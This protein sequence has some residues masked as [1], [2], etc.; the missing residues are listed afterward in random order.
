MVGLLILFTCWP[1]IHAILSLHFGF[2][3]W[4]FAGWGMYATP[5]TPK[6]ETL[7]V[8]IIPDSFVEDTERMR[9]HVLRPAPL[10]PAFR[11]FHWTQDGF[12]EI[13]PARE[14]HDVGRSVRLVKVLGS[15]GSVER[16]GESI[17]RDYG[18]RRSNPKMIVLVIQPRVHPFQRI[19]YAEVNAYLY[20]DHQAAKLGT[21]Q[22]DETDINRLLVALARGDAI[23]DGSQFRHDGSPGSQPPDDGPD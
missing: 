11:V 10:Q 5:Y 14:P 12:R 3:A 15:R 16:L 7:Q 6:T 9:A 20:R 18:I 19:T 4:K 1:P 13:A 8:Y 2:S 22:S 17:V 21:F 23:G